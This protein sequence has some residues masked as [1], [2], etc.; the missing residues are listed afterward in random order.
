[1]CLGGR[2]ILQLV[3]RILSLNFDALSYFFIQTW[4]I[5]HYCPVLLHS[6]AHAMNIK[7]YVY[8]PNN[9]YQMIKV[10]LWFS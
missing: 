4:R 7:S 8:I 10:S 3:N 2:R 1:M 6:N 9:Y 5:L